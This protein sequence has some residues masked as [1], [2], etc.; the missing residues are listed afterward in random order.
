MTK[1]LAYHVRDDE[2]PFIDEIRLFV[3]THNA[4][5]KAF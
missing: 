1:I 2:Q 4:D 5:G 3:A